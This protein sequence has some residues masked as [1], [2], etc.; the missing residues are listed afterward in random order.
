MPKMKTKRSAAKR[1]KLTASGK[2]K[3][4]Q[5]FHSH[6]LSK[7]SSGKSNNLAK[8]TLVSKADEK[9]VKKMLCVA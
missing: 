9:N 6:E 4:N 1:F 3:R 2:V 8:T 5:A 7:L